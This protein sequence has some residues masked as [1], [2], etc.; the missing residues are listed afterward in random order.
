[1][2]LVSYYRLF[3]G[4]P[5]CRCHKWEPPNATSLAWISRVWDGGVAADVGL[6]AGG[7]CLHDVGADV[8]V[9]EEAVGGPLATDPLRLE[10]ARQSGE[11]EPLPKV[12]KRTASKN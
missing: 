11:G 4:A 2:Q 1:M 10:V 7:E 12:L 9:R 6:L 3:S 8:A 5:Q